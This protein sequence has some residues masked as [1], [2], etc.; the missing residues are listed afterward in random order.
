MYETILSPVD[1][2]G[3]ELKNRIIFAP[4]TMGLSQEAWLEKLRTIARGGCAMIIIGDVPAS[5]WSV[6]PPLY[7]ADG[8]AHYR[9]MVEAVHGEGCKVCAQLYLSDSVMEDGS[10]GIRPVP[11]EEVGAYVSQL[12]AAE[13]RRYGAMFGDAAL[14]ARQA[15]FDMIQI[16]GD[17]M[18]GSLCSTVFNRRED[19]YGGSAENRAR[20]VKECVCAVRNWLP[21]MPIAD[22][23]TNR[24]EN[25]H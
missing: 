24:Q 18:L 21:H 2:G 10:G 12:P 20:F 11:K 14:L 17:R 19:E 8:L 1:Y 23:L 25:P 3:I 16:L 15:G 6:E 22:T 4:T 7:T 5:P 9:R 13:L